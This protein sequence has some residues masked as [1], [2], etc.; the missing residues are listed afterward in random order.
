MTRRAISRHCRRVP[1]MVSL[2][3]GEDGHDED[4][5]GGD[6]GEDVTMAEGDGAV[7]GGAD[8]DDVIAVGGS[9]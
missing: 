7:D 6:I 8:E 5:D 2:G 3:F 1:R 9:A 4:P